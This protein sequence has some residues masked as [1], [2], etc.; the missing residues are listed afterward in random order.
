MLINEIQEREAA[1]A[2]GKPVPALSSSTDVR[3]LNMDDFKYAH[4][5]VKEE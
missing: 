5:Q 2:E 4:E 1:I 3:H